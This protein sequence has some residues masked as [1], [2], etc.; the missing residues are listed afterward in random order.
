MYSI[1]MFTQINAMQI[2]I[3][4]H[5]YG[6]I[7]MSWYLRY[8][9][10]FCIPNSIHHIACRLFCIYIETC[11]LSNLNLF[12]IVFHQ[13]I[14]LSWVYGIDRVFD[15]L[16]QMNM[17]FSGWVRTYWWATWTLVTPIASFVS[18]SYILK[19]SY[20]V[21]IPSGPSSLLRVKW[22]WSRVE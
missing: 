4:P 15:N 14:V 5:F 17:R 2:T 13:V 3:R 21:C 19:H 1:L 12:L 16:S 20:I 18:I 11:T 22:I 6:F 10:I 9:L 8:V 7:V